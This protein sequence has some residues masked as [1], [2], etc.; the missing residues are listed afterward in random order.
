MLNV[1]IIKGK[2]YDSLRLKTEPNEDDQ[3]VKMIE[4]KWVFSSLFQ[5]GGH[6]TG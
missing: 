3:C 5:G 6:W 2:G 1:D 4:M